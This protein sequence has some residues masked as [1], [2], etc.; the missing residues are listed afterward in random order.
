[1]LRL[2]VIFSFALTALLQVYF[3]KGKCVSSISEKTHE[4]DSDDDDDDD[5]DATDGVALPM[6]D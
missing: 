5:H 2:V 3:L 6:I 1:M 4:Q